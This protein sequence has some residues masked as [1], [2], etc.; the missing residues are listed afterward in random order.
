[1][2]VFAI[3]VVFCVRFPILLK[4]QAFEK[5]QNY[6]AMNHVRNYS[7]YFMILCRK[8]FDSTMF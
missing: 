2:C 6:G 5:E 1:M 4:Y 7:V 8:L 3:A